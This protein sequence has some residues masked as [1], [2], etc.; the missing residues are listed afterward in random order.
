MRHWL[1]VWLLCA[2]CVADQEHLRLDR[3]G[4]PDASLLE[5][6]VAAVVVWKGQTDTLTAPATLPLA[7]HSAREGDAGEA[8]VDGQW[9]RFEVQ[10]VWDSAAWYG[11]VWRA[12]QSG[13]FSDSLWLAGHFAGHF[14]GTDAT[15]LSVGSGCW[16][17]AIDSARATPVATGE[18]VRITWQQG[19]WDGPL[20]GTPFELAV[21][22]GDEDQLLPP[23][24]RAVERWGVPATWRL[25]C[26]ARE[27]FGAE[28]IPER[29]LPPHVP[30][31]FEV[32]VS[33]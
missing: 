2:G 8:F 28:G 13:R 29:G 16:C 20:N 3:L 31:V 18:S 24:W 14:T 12:V 10:R 1:G 22:W 25:V 6:A 33:R 26:P 5:D 21:R 23:F 7:L 32:Q 17:A 27:A 15:R 4:A 9:R 19:P 30:V 11:P